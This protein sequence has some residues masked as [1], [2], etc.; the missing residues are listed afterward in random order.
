MGVKKQIMNSCW[1]PLKQV[2]QAP[3]NS[4]SVAIFDNLADNL[5]TALVQNDTLATQERP[6]QQVVPQNDALPSRERQSY[7][8]TPI[9]YLQ[10]AVHDSSVVTCPKQENV[11]GNGT[12]RHLP[13]PGSVAPPAGQ[14]RAGLQPSFKKEDKKKEKKKGGLLSLFDRKLFSHGNNSLESGHVESVERAPTNLQQRS[15]ANSG[16]H[17]SNGDATHQRSGS[18][19]DHAPV[20]TEVRLVNGNA[21]TVVNNVSPNGHIANASRVVGMAE[22]GVASKREPSA[23]AEQ[24]AIVSSRAGKNA[25]ME[26]DERLPRP[27]T[28]AIEGTSSQGQVITEPAESSTAYNNQIHTPPTTSGAVSSVSD[29]DMIDLA[30]TRSDLAPI[31]NGHPPIMNGHVPREEPKSPDQPLVTLNNSS[32]SSGRQL[33]Q[34]NGLIANGIPPIMIANSAVGKVPNGVAPTNVSTA[35]TTQMPNNVNGSRSK[36][37][38]NRDLVQN[39]PEIAYSVS[40]L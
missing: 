29:D 34:A 35:I 40:V 22:V 32:G 7:T 38:T 13:M 9:P 17:R 27:S 20:S 3:A 12:H 26:V 1:F 8:V 28:L 36:F 23:V 6:T 33:K 39:S 4:A 21:Q 25:E 19:G 37:M 16:N 15:S 5:Q 10:N 30:P 24:P 31:R 11:P 14:Q 18:N 2:S